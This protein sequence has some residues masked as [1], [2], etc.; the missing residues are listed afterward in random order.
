MTKQGLEERQAELEQSISSYRSLASNVT[1]E[2]NRL[3]ERRQELLEHISTQQDEL[4]E[5]LRRQLAMYSDE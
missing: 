4:T 5:V 3:Q 1:E 2:I